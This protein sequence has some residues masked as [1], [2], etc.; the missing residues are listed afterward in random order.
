MQER[1]EERPL[2]ELFSE[3]SGQVGT[4]VRQEVELARTEMTEKA[5][6]A[7][8]HVG[9][10]GAGALV[11][12]A[13]FLGLLGAAVLL[14][15]TLGLPLWLS[16]LIVALVVAALAYFLVQKGRQGLQAEN[17]AP[18]RTIRTLKEDAEWAKDQ[19]K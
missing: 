9:F 14:L 7:G 10:I 6:R 8:K 17:L 2:G 3:L 12:Y 13:A 11:A 1:K 4:L 15:A 18:S 19:T 5:T 16:A